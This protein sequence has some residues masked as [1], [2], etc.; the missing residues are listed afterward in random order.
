MTVQSP[1]DFAHK[2]LLVSGFW[3]ESLNSSASS[4]QRGILGSGGRCGNWLKV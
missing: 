4:G 2:P 1:S 3:G